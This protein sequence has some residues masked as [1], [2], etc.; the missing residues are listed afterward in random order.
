MELMIV[1]FCVILY[2]FLAREFL[3]FVSART[4][5]RFYH[6]LSLAFVILLPTWD[7]VLGCVV[8]FPACLIV[9][10]WGIY[11]TAITDGIYYEGN[12]K[13]AI[14]TDDF[15]KEVFTSSSFHDDGRGFSYIESLITARCSSYYQSCAPISPK[16]YRCTVIKKYPQSYRVLIPA[17]RCTP[18]ESAESN[19]FVMIKR[20]RFGIC[21]LRF[22][23][24]RNRS[25]DKLMGEYREV[26]LRNFLPFFNWKF[27]DGRAELGR[28]IAFSCPGK[29]RFYDFQYT[30]LRP[31]IE[32]K[33]DEQ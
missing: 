7:V 32:A 30:V 25:T 11:E 20:M 24:I 21:E 28:E 10:K 23:K 31:K 2:V 1:L 19:Y 16:V 17:T 3:K 18:V 5:S 26:A 9:P 13:N 6:W 22:M 33:E 14:Y 15:G 29:S 8:Y 27:F 12:V 4:Y